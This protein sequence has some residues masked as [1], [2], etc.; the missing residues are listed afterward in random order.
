ME[1]KAVREVKKTL[2]FQLR[3]YSLLNNMCN[4]ICLIEDFQNDKYGRWKSRKQYEK[5]CG[6]DSKTARHMN[7]YFVL[8][9][10]VKELSAFETIIAFLLRMFIV[11]ANNKRI[12]LFFS[13]RAR[14][15]FESKLFMNPVIGNKG[16]RDCTVITEQ[17]L[18][19][20]I[21][22]VNKKHNNYPD[23]SSLIIF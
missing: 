16:W 20:I 17:T 4:T 3:F 1:W 6:S 13:Y 7:F 11:P 2:L 19:K 18:Q 8:H 15:K 12:T 9:V 14:H 22:D 23:S 10:F 5:S 21:R